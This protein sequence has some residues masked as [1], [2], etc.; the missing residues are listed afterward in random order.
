MGKFA[1]MEAQCNIYHVTLVSFPGC[2]WKCNVGIEKI[3]K[4]FAGAA[5]IGAGICCR[6]RRRSFPKG[7]HVFSR[8][9][10]LCHIP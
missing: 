1:L 8:H 3:W 2:S 10:E 5:D 6:W 7:V 4:D 9:K